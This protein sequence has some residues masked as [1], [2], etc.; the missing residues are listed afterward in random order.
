MLKEATRTVVALTM[1]LLPCLS[2]NYAAAQ[3]GE[4][5]AIVVTER[6]QG[7]KNALSTGGQQP[8][9]PGCETAASSVEEKI[10]C[11][12]EELQKFIEANLKYP[13]IA[14]A[15]DFKPVIVR[16]RV[17]VDANGRIH[18][19]RILELGVKEY[20]ANALAVFTKME[21]DDMKWVPGTFEGQAVRSPVMV[22]VHFSWEG[23]NKAFPTLFVADGSDDVYELPD[24]VPAFPSCRQKGKRDEQIRD[25][26]LD[27]LDDFFNRNM[28]YPED[29]LR[30]GLEGDIQVEFVVGKDGQIRN[31]V[32]KN[33]IGLGCGEETRRLFNLANEKNIG[34]LPG[35]EK[36]QKVNVLFK[37][38]V[39]FRIKNN[40][41]P[42][43]KLASADPRPFF[44]T[45]KI[46]YEDFQST[47]L[48]LPKSK[49]IGTCSFGVVDVKFKINRQTGGVAVTEIIDY[50]NLGKEFKTAVNTFLQETNGQWR[51]QYPGLGDETQYYLSFPLATNSTTCPDALKEYKEQIYKSLGSALLT[52]KNTTFNAGLEALDKAV[53]L[54]PADN[55]IRHLRGMALYKNGRTVEGCVDLFF[56]SKQNR[57]IPVP[58]SCK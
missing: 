24:D 53:R 15:P 35:E 42:M 9:F 57:E 58:A 21:Q 46:G 17:T 55:K 27:Y 39:R 45:G 1:A 37:T 25:C 36:G 19:P 34:W 28:I 50:N 14:K 49:E 33:D 54:Y 6:N 51:V 18:S 4:S 13:E 11:A 47:Y 26:S 38:T 48:K 5:A 3:N 16:V 12:E 2:P 10:K 56:V 20:D 8:R 52:D 44:I 41:R 32:L 23:R 43:T 29:A 31:V 7:T 40:V 22:T 30:V